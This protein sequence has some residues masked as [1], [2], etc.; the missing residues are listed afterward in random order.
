[1]ADYS[2]EPYPPRADRYAPASSQYDDYAPSGS[3]QRRP[4]DDQSQMHPGYEPRGRDPPSREHYSSY[5]EPRDRESRARGQY[6]DY[7]EP[8]GHGLPSRDQ[9]SEPR[10]REP[11][12][13][14]NEPPP[15][16]RYDDTRRT[17]DHH[18]RSGI[19]PPPTDEELAASAQEPLPHEGNQLAPYEE[20]KAY[21]EYQRGE[22]E[23]EAYYARP[24][25][26]D[27][28]RRPLSIDRYD[29]RPPPPE[30]HSRR[31]PSADY[32]DH[33]P[34]RHT[35]DNDRRRDE[36]PPREKERD[37]AGPLIGGGAGALLGHELIG[38]GALGTIGGAVVGAS[39]FSQALVV[40]IADI[41]TSCCQRHG[42]L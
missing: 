11:V 14:Y 26:T 41:Y 39:E 29:Q 35:N 30:H 15:A 38:K 42:E 13:S 25:P 27:Y 21:A 20:E 18:H 1:M 33:R 31:A 37:L 40:D 7:N 24:P 16:N 5:N 22:E 17:S 10:R 6:D 4:Y 3:G 8:Q 19:P 36:Q 28:D 2:R 34:R 9:Y 23:R 32:Y 12:D